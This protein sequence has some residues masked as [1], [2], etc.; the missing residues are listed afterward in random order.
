MKFSFLISIPA[1]AGAN[2]LKLPDLIGS[3]AFGDGAA[4]Y[5]S[6]IVSAALSGFAAI[7]LLTYTV[8][9]AKLRYFSYYCF[10]IG[11]TAV[12]CEIFTVK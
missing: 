2:I 11:V 5:I 4:V 9:K 3:G 12:I 8:K 7:K 1:I 10:I 6:G